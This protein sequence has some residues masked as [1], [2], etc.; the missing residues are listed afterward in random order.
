MKSIQQHLPPNIVA[1]TN[2]NVARFDELYAWILACQ[3][4]VIHWQSANYGLR[5]DAM[6]NPG[7]DLVLENNVLK[8]KK[9]IGTTSTGVPIGILPDLMPAIELNLNELP[10]PASKEV[11]IIVATSLKAKR[12]AVGT[13]D[14]K[15]IPTRLPF[16]TLPYRLEWH[17]RDAFPVHAD[18]LKI[19][20][21]IYDNNSWQLQDYLPACAVIGG[22]SLLWQKQQ[23]YLQEVEQLYRALQQIISK[24]NTAIESPLKVSLEQFCRSVGRYMAT[25]IPHLKAISVTHNPDTLIH[26]LQSLAELINFEWNIHY[27]PEERRELVR[28]N[29]RNTL[30][31]DFNLQVVYDLA[32]YQHQPSHWE[33]SIQQIDAFVQHFVQPL[34]I[35][36]QQ[37]AIVEMQVN[38]TWDQPANRPVTNRKTP[39]APKP[40][41]PQTGR[42][43][44]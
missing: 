29:V 31:E 30:A 40:T 37:N 19:G 25:S 11:A 27:Q 12:H 43:G 35:I 24:I 4:D 23:S 36:A 14:G 20:E 13:P 2:F 22:H 21:L 6:G 7:F 32:N 17:E 42:L 18:G 38:N 5:C 34:V 44:W 33:E 15:E 39:S 3:S 28:Y 8:L 1:G 26:F 10:I 9:C 41:P 16:S